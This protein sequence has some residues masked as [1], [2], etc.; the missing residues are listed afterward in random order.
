[1]AFD[2]ELTRFPL[3]GLHAAVRCE[4]CHQTRS[5]KGA[6]RACVSCHE[7]THHAGSLGSNCASCHNASGWGRW[8]FNHDTQ[9]RYPLTGS[10]RGLQCQACHRQAAGA[11]VTAPT[12]CFACHRGDDAHQGSFGRSCEK[13][14]NTSSFRSGLSGR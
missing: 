13:C 10:H 12:D 5:Y 7:D 11:K 9:T 6:P 3:V 4:K 1:V 2:H 8:R 14:H